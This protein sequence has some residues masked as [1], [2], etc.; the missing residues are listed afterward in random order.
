M[1]IFST[2]L[3][4]NLTFDENPKTPSNESCN[5]F[6]VAGSD[7]YPLP[8]AV[9]MLVPSFIYSFLTIKSLVTLA[10]IEAAPTTGN[11]ASAFSDTVNFVLGALSL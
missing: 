3:Q 7:G 1:N 2:V 4:E 11:L 5:H 10:Q 9:G 8:I 6:F